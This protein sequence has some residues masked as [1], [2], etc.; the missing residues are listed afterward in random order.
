M[1][2]RQTQEKQV[3][4]LLSSPKPDGFTRMQIAQ[5]LG[6]IGTYST[7]GG[8]SLFGPGSSFIPH[9]RQNRATGGTPPNPHRG[10][11]LRR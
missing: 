7:S 4:D 5:C 3:F 10:Q 2:T 11:T 1:N 6:M 9:F 8:V